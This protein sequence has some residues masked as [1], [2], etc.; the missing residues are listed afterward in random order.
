MKLAVV[1]ERLFSLVA[2]AWQPFA[3]AGR[4]P[5]PFCTFT[6]GPAEVQLHDVTVTL[7]ASNVFVPTEEGVFVSPSLILHYVDAHRYVPPEPFQRAVWA[8][9]PMRSLEYLKAIRRLGVHRLGTPRG[10]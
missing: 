5:C 9:P 2:N 4:H 3:T 10:S 6:G 8:C 7:G 1:F